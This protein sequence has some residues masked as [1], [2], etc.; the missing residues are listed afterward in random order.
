VF[1][2]QNAAEIVKMQRF[3]F[4][5]QND[6]FVFHTVSDNSW[7]PVDVDVWVVV[8]ENLKISPTLLLPVLCAV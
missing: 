7:N 2:V 1:G 8:Y 4:L 3:S 6:F 5:P